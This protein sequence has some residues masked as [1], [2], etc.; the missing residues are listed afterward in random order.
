MDLGEYS[1]EI[2]KAFVNT[3]IRGGRID[4]P[5]YTIKLKVKDIDISDV[6]GLIYRYL[7]GEQ[8]R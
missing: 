7:K 2:K 4:L 3:S 5:D 6:T 8:T 1:I